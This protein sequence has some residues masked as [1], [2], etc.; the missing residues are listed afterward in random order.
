MEGAAKAGAN[1]VV[2]GVEVEEL[3][4]GGDESGP[5]ATEVVAVERLVKDEAAAMLAGFASLGRTSCKSSCGAPT[6]RSR[7]A[8]RAC[9]ACGGARYHVSS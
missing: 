9:C 7:L 5:T 1:K 2:E 4:A 6:S 8:T 3:K